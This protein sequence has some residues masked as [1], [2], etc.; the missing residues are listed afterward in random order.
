MIDG[1][2]SAEYHYLANSPLVEQI[3]FRNGEATRMTTVKKYDRLNRLELIES[4]PSAD[5]PIS[6]AYG[7]NQANQRTNAVLADGTA[8]GLRVRRPRPSDRGQ[9]SGS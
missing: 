5:D 1:E 2:Y 7:Y 6:Y 4:Q 8:W 9:E 3:D